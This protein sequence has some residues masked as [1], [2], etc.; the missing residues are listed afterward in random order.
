MK[1]YIVGSEDGAT[2]SYELFVAAQHA[3]RRNIPDG[4]NHIIRRR[5]SHTSRI[6]FSRA[7]CQ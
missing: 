1:S 6:L 5:D 3:T 2:A 7:K 4:R